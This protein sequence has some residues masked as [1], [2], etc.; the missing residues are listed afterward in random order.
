MRHH[1]LTA[2]LATLLFVGHAQKT[3]AMEVHDPFEDVNRAVAAFNKTVDTF[4]FRPLAK[5]YTYIMPDFAEK[6]VSNFFDNLFYPTTIVNQFLQGN[7]KL[8]G[9]DTGRFLINTTLGIGG[10]FDVASAGSDNLEKHKEDFGQTFGTWGFGNGPYLIIPIFGPSTLRDGVG[11]LAGIYT[12][13]LTYVEDDEWRYG[14]WG[15]SILDARVDFFKKEELIS[16]D[17]YLFVRDAYIHHRQFLVKNGQAEENDPF[18]D[19]E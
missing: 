5:G 4:F 9:Q 7:F 18:L 12:N 19:G 8:G 6:G 3:T 13:P 15:L 17:Q 11:T 14:L 10:L 1:L 2:V 16:G